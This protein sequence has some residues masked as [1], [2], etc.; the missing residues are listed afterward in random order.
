MPQGA[1]LTTV[2]SASVVSAYSSPLTQVPAVEATPG[3]QV[4]GA[5]YLPLPTTARLDALMVVSASGL[6]V[7]ARLFDLDANAVV[8]GSTTQSTSTTPERTLSG[9]VALTGQHNYQ[10]QAE[11]VGDVGF[12]KFAVVLSATVSD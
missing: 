8:S 11:C 12:D 3:W 10:I 7:R 9:I 1:A 6:T 4:L 2:D 5:F